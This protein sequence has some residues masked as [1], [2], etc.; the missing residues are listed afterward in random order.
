MAI[1]QNYIDD[2]ATQIASMTDTLQQEMVR[3][4]L[5]LSKDRRFQTIDEFLLAMEQLNIEQIVLTKADNIIQGYN[6]AHNQILSEMVLFAEISEDTLRALA[7]FSRSSFADSLGKMGGVIKTEIIKG[8]MGGVSEQGIFQAIQQQAGL[9]NAQMQTLVTTGLNDFSASV[10]KVMLDN[11]P[12]NE[13]VRYTG[14][15]DEKTRPF[16]IRAWEAGALTKK[17]I[18]QRLPTNDQGGDPYI[19]RGGY[20]CRH[21]WFPVKASDKSKDVREDA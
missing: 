1:N 21:Q 16:C 14:P 5:K 11:A 13:K 15:I 2:V 6:V 9:S 4:L 7:N 17:E 19:S 8:V 10:A 12:D 18:A 3:D 20:N